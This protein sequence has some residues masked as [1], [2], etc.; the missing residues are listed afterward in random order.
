MYMIFFLVMV[1]LFVSLVNI[2]NLC[3]TTLLKHGAIPSTGVTFSCN[4][5]ENIIHRCQWQ[6]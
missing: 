1:F 6:Q 2:L 4:E 3:S 5:I